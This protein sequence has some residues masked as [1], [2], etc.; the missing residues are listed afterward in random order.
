MFDEA[1]ARELLKEIADK[2]KLQDD[3]IIILGAIIHQLFSDKSPI[4]IE[5]LQ[6]KN[7]SPSFPPAPNGSA[8]REPDF[9]RLA[10]S[11]YRLIGPAKT[12]DQNDP[13]KFEERVAEL[14]DRCFYKSELFKFAKWVLIIALVFIGAGTASLGG[15]TLT[16]RSQAENAQKDLE[17]VKTQSNAI[18]KQIEENEQAL[19]VKQN[20]AMKNIQKAI[21]D[22]A[23]Q[24]NDQLL[25]FIEQAKKALGEK[26]KTAE[27]AVEEQKGKMTTSV[28]AGITFV[29]AEK[30][31]FL[32]GLSDVNTAIEAHKNNVREYV[33]GEKRNLATTLTAASADIARQQGRFA[34]D[35]ALLLEQTTGKVEPE[36]A[37][38]L[39][40]IAQAAANG[41]GKI[42]EDVKGKLAAIETRI[43]AEIARIQ[44]TVERKKSDLDTVSAEKVQSLDAALNEKLKLLNQQSIAADKAIDTVVGSL[45]A[46]E[47]SFV[48]AMNSRLSAWDQRVVLEVKR[49][50]GLAKTSD[51]LQAKIKDVAEQFGA[52]LPSLKPALD[53]INELKSGTVT[54]KL[55]WIGTVL[56]NSAFL[57]IANL[58]IGLLAIL[59]AVISIVLSLRQKQQRPPPGEPVEAV[60]TPDRA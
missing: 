52:L 23:R 38:R 31:K 34:A 5:F 55:P 10:K 3:D 42:D 43:D 46:R 11:A 56:E 15:F 20:D 21:E 41:A 27:T 30:N 28:A 4:A 16:L 39:S 37:Q 9:R 40:V 35:L 49:I 22:K 13:K 25:A 7:P 44:Q 24:Y 18:I 57:F 45:T 32:L 60:R 29:E 1:R 53:V 48:S 14:V 8:D 47:T 58:A 26:V 51:D 19:Q 17:K 54:G 6:L 12:P 2:E 33:E 59:I 36:V 50:D